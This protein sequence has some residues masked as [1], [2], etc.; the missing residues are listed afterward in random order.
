MWCICQA[1]D[2]P[3]LHNKS[4]MYFTRLSSFFQHLA[5][6]SPELYSISQS[7]FLDLPSCLVLQIVKSCTKI[8]IVNIQVLSK[9]WYKYQIH[10]TEWVARYYPSMMLVLL[11]S[12]VLC[13]H[14]SRPLPSSPG[15]HSGSSQRL[16]TKNWKTEA[17]LAEN[18]WGWSAPAQL[19]PGDGKMARYG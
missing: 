8:S 11:W 13:Q 17:N 1:L 6:G 16:A 14:R 12:S 3:G 2:S 9:F 15:L 5:N 7:S 4:P 10:S 19:W 18:G